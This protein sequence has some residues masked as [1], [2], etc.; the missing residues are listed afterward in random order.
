MI[1]VEQVKK[2]HIRFATKGA[3]AVEVILIDGKMFVH[4]EPLVSKTAMTSTS[5]I[6]SQ[7]KEMELLKEAK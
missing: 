7:E 4:S 1:Q 2:D 3:S 6:R 5:T